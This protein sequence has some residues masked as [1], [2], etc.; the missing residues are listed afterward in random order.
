MSCAINFFYDY[1]TRG[2]FYISG[3][4]R[5]QERYSIHK[6][7]KQLC[8]W[9]HA[10]LFCA[11][12]DVSITDIFLQTD[13]LTR[14]IK[15]ST[16]IRHYC[17]TRADRKV[18]KLFF[19]GWNTPNFETLPSLYMCIVIQ[20]ENLQPWGTSPTCVPT[21]QCHLAHRTS[22]RQ[23]LLLCRPSS[24]HFLGGKSPFSHRL[25][26]LVLAYYGLWHV[27]LVELEPKNFKFYESAGMWPTYEVFLNKKKRVYETLLTCP[28]SACPRL[29]S[30]WWKIEC[31]PN[32]WGRPCYEDPQKK[33]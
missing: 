33:E 6:C 15:F 16:V 12:C 31:M 5:D 32:W 10:I 1:S 26:D 30:L 11:C 27:D 7:C 28:L 24:Y 25:L 8:K 20:H 23:A 2:E 14:F 21:C 29:G 18:H 22:S 19:N 3:E 9:V 13:N 4:R 17:S